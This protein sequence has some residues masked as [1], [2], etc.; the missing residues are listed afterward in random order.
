[1]ENYNPFWGSLFHMFIMQY[2]HFSFCFNVLIPWC[3][4]AFF[5]QFEDPNVFVTISFL[6]CCC[7][8]VI[9][10]CKI[11]VLNNSLFS[12]W[13][14]LLPCRNSMLE[15]ISSS[16]RAG[17]SETSTN[18]EAS[19]HRPP[20]SKA[21]TMSPASN[22]V[23][24]CSLS[25]RVFMHT[26]GC[27]TGRDS[28]AHGD[29]DRQLECHLSS[30]RH[31]AHPGHCLLGCKCP[32][33]K[34]YWVRA[35]GPEAS[36]AVCERP[37]IAPCIR[38]KQKQPQPQQ[39]GAK[40]VRRQWTQDSWDTRGAR[41]C[42]RRLSGTSGWLGKNYRL[43]FARLREGGWWPTKPCRSNPSA[44][45]VVL[46]IQSLP[47]CSLPIAETSRESCALHQSTMTKILPDRRI[48]NEANRWHTGVRH[49]ARGSATSTADLAPRRLRPTIGLLQVSWRW[50]CGRILVSRCESPRS[51]C[52]R[53]S[54]PR[55]LT[56]RH[57]CSCQKVTLPRCC[58][59][60]AS[61]VE[62]KQRARHRVILELE[63]L[64]QLFESFLCDS[65]PV[66]GR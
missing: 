33:A 45:N 7:I 42:I 66:V 3:L 14:H 25:A 46:A 60:L 6:S 32:R 47:R 63:L 61:C 56:L 8:T 16:T 18:S 9:F 15:A 17:P 59:R 10:Q 2:F 40:H 36:S 55:R 29:V 34:S 23:Y 52:L 58:K 21:T 50:W 31:P 39:N 62:G 44:A 54:R 12:L 65:C 19:G 35:S 22:S 13:E 53:D 11:I 24:F 48:G 5:V 20:V 28:A 49:F 1:M 27:S 41:E 38:Y 64:N 26:A 57:P 30:R 43:P 37:A 51:Q 4:S